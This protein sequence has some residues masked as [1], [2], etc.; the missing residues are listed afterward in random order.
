MSTRYT[1]QLVEAGFQSSV[2]SKGNSHDNAMVESVIRLLKTETVNHQGPQRAFEFLEYAN[3][4][5]I[6]WDDQR[7][8]HIPINYVPPAEL[9]LCYYAQLI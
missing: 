9:E 5:C 3:L 8:R 6:D 7:R 4:V 1:D 2:G